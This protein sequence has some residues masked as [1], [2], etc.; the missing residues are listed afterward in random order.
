MFGQ[1][2]RVE[3]DEYAGPPLCLLQVQIGVLAGSGGGGGGVERC[4]PSPADAL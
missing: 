1:H 2:P 4:S 3:K